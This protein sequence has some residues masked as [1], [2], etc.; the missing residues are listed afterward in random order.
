MSGELWKMDCAQC[1]IFRT[2][3]TEDEA[4][5]LRDDHQRDA[6]HT[7]A[8]VTKIRAKAYEGH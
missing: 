8:I 5:K 1:A 2:A 3:P 4:N 7:S 6:S